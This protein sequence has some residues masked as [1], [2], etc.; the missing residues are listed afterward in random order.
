MS[1]NLDKSKRFDC[2][3]VCVCKVRL[4]GSC[5]KRREVVTEATRIRSEKLREHWYRE[6]N[7][8]S[9]EGKRVERDGDDNV[10]HMWE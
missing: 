8:R 2:V 7:A 3:C 10:E 9:L 5:I 4:V 6:G 1:Q